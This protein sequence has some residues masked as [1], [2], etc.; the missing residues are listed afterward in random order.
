VAKLREDGSAATVLAT[1]IRTMHGKPVAAI[2]AA[3][4]V[5]MDAALLEGKA[6]HRPPIS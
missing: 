2:C 1:T 5:L 6:F 3:P 4:L